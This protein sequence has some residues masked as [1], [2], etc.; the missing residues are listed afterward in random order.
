MKLTKLLINSSPK[1]ESKLTL[2]SSE[3]DLEIQSPITSQQERLEA[4]HYS[5]SMSKSRRSYDLQQSKEKTGRV[6]TKSVNNLKDSQTRKQTL[7]Q[8][9]YIGD[10]SPQRR[11]QPKVPS[12]TLVNPVKEPKYGICDQQPKNVAPVRSNSNNG[13]SSTLKLANNKNESRPNSRK[14]TQT[15]T[16]VSTSYYVLPPS[17]KNSLVDDELKEEAPKAER[18]QTFLRNQK[19]E[20]SQAKKQKDFRK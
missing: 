17:G 5:N 4:R 16:F 7:V 14:R 13:R 3:C 15:T 20:V 2:R 6:L 18:K 8:E 19:P 1:P 12:L 10:K 11:S 9:N